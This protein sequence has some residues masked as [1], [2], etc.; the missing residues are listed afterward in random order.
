MAKYRRV[1]GIARQIGIDAIA[2]V[3]AARRHGV[4][5]RCEV[6]DTHVRWARMIGEEPPDD[7]REL[8]TYTGVIVPWVP[9]SGEGGVQSAWQQALRGD[10]DPIAT[11]ATKGSASVGYIKADD[12]AL[13]NVLGWRNA[14]GHSVRGHV[15]IAIADLRIESRGLHRLDT[16]EQWHLRTLPGGLQLPE[17]IEVVGVARAVAASFDGSDKTGAPELADAIRAWLHHHMDADVRGG[18]GTKDKVTKWL[19]GRGRDGTSAK[20][21]A[22]VAHPRGRKSGGAPKSV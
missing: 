10:A 9:G 7:L 5:I 1:E 12:G 8:P 13:G 21:I 16:A 15:S 17:G 22:T 19:M 3:E 6:R 14:D 4:P 2:V 11:A 20:R 18:H